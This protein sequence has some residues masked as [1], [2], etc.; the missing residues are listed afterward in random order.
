MKM[1]VH[2][3]LKKLQQAC[4]LLI[5]I[6]L[7]PYL[8]ACHKTVHATH[9]T[10]VDQIQTIMQESI[11]INRGQRKVIHTNKRRRPLPNNINSALLPPLSHYIQHEVVEEPRF[12]VAANKVP[13]REF[14]MGLVAG[15]PYNMVVHPNVGGEITLN[16]KNVTVKQTM[17]AIRDIYGY[18]YHRS[19]Y[20]FEISPP[21]LE[22][23]LFH[24][25]YLDVQRRGRSYTQLTTGQ[26]SNKVGTVSVGGAG[27]VGTSVPIA[28][29]GS[30]VPEGIGTISSLETKTEMEF[31]RDIEKS[32]R[33]M[34]PKDDVHNVT[35]NSQTGVISVRA[36]PAELHRIGNFID[37]LQSN[38][39]RQ[40]ILEAKILEVA[41]DDQY[42]A[43]IDWSIL[44]NPA[45]VDA[46]NAPVNQAGIG[47]NGNQLFPDTELSPFNGIFAIRIKGNFKLFI[48]L[49]QTQGNVQVLSSPHISTINNQ[50][51]VIKVGSDE[52]FVTGVST[53]NTI[54]GSN[55]LPSQD[56]SLTPFFSG[57]TLDVT[58]EISRDKMVTLHIHPSISRVT[59]QTKTIGLGTSATGTP[60]NLT[61]P[62][63]FSTIRESDSIVRVKSGEVIVIGG[64]MQNVMRETLAETPWLGKI[65][66]VGSFFRRT[67]QTSQKSELVI[68]LRPVILN[69]CNT[70]ARLEEDKKSF[71]ILRRPNHE[72]GLRRVFGNEAE[73]ADNE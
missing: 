68:L 41:L 3:V 26:I 40:V 18:E 16:L 12:D 51:A 34:L 33:G 69:K 24:I 67:K 13:A 35:V 46:N 70:L 29:P 9:K 56:V 38:L 39:N 53:T 59:N 50:K 62:L 5:I 30:T 4:Y 58:P 10:S 73:R 45:L 48:N 27:S 66:F 22:T 61:L 17:D 7:T 31:W 52:F 2:R 55:T 11:D 44:N 21:T 28:V 49:L 6:L 20:G 36:F 42:Q 37:K 19:S 15:T 72:G 64:L 14:F 8:S 63:A 54:I 57:I 65:P 1:G 32:I 47:Q 25:N 60:N 23:Q 71:Q 43:G